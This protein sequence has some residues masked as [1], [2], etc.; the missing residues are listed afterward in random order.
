VRD[1]YQRVVDAITGRYPD[2]GAHLD[3]VRDD[4]LAFAA[5]S[6]NA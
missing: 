2:A 3:D 4:L 6:E 1:Q 5:F